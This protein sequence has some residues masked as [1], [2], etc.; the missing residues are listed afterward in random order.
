MSPGLRM[1][2]MTLP[3]PL[4]SGS[5]S[6]TAVVGLPLPPWLT[7]EVGGAVADVLVQAERP[8]APAHSAATDQSRRRGPRRVT[9]QSSDRTAAK[10]PVHRATVSRLTAAPGRAAHAKARI[11]NQIPTSV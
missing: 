8:T 1:P 2:T 4:V 11:A 7:C 9:G 3:S 6:R 10:R 5:D